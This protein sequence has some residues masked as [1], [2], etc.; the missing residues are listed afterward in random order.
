MDRRR[1]LQVSSVAL[2]TS[3]KLLAQTPIP[4]TTLGK[5]GLRV[6]RIAV[7]G[8]DMSLTSSEIGVSVIRK[9]L[10]LG[11]NF[12]DSAHSYHDG[13]ADETYGKA[14]DVSTRQKVHL[15]SKSQARTADGA[16]KELEETLRRMNTDYLDLWQCHGIATFEEIDKI[17]GPGGAAEGFVKA[18]QQGKVRHIGFTGHHDPNVH[19]RMID[20]FDGWETIQHPVNLVDPHYESF[21]KTVLP[22]AAAKGLGRLAMKSNAMGGITGHKVATIPE[23]LRFTWSQP[24]DVLVSGMQTPEQV[25]QNV[26]SCKTFQKMTDEEI[27]EL[28]ARTGNGPTGTEVE[29]YKKGPDGAMQRIHIDGEYV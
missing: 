26:A 24:I 28:L 17:L 19:A 14:L 12:F 9:A 27:A 5:S 1:F 7:G 8:W 4:M 2:G 22:K 20:S 13:R 25:E 23:C 3:A 21:I 16:M 10:D 11:I 6:T 18:K 29:Q 15:M